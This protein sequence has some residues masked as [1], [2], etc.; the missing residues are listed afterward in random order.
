MPKEDYLLKYLEKLSRVIAA[1]LG[2]RDKGFPEDALRLA[3]ETYKELLNINLE[4][5]RIMPPDHF[6][7]VLK[8]NNYNVDYIESV[9]GILL[10]TAKSYEATGQT[11]NAIIFYE[12][13]LKVVYLLN[14]KDKTFSFERETLIASL[15]EKVGKQ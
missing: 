2:F 13:T 1:M 11:E 12:K 4:E 6:I 8:K 14:E 10:E 15:A 5:T 3:D 7:E 9:S